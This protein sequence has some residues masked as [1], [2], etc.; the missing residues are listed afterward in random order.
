MCPAL[1]GLFKDIIHTHT[2]TCITQEVSTT[3]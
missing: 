1:S 2:D 3:P